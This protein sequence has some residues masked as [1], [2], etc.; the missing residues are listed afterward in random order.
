MTIETTRYTSLILVTDF[1]TPLKMA[2]DIFIASLG[3]EEMSESDDREHQEAIETNKVVEGEEEGGME[4]EEGA[5]EEEEEE[6]AVEE[7]VRRREETS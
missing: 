1:E 6:E 2:M 5:V 7:Y 3:L 4:S